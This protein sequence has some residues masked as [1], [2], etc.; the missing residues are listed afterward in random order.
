M[1]SISISYIFGRM[2]PS[3]IYVVLILIFIL[4]RFTGTVN[5]ESS[6]RNGIKRVRFIIKRLLNEV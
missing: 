2:L 5:A 3:F 1:V 6:I 4:G